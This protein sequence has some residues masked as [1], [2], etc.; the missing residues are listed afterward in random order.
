ML[1]YNEKYGSLP[2]AFVADKE[3][4][5]MHS[6]RVLLLPFLGEQGLYGS[7]NF[8]E[9][10]DGPNNRLLLERMPKIFACPLDRDRDRFMTSYV[11]V[12]GRSTAFPGATTVSLDEITDDRTLTA[13]VVEGAGASVQWLEPRDLDFDVMSFEVNGTFG[14]GVRAQ[15]APWVIMSDGHGE[16]LDPK[17][18]SSHKVRALL[19]IDGG[20]KFSMAIGSSLKF[21]E[22]PRKAK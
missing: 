17:E 11:V 8:S 20:E 4:R 9:P 10:W 15:H 21:E 3:G 13:L 16:S 5:R 18:W 14:M 1:L 7:Y 12:V 2:P 22:P 6:W 19:T